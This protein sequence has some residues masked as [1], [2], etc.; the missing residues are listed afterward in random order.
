MTSSFK[1][2]SI[3]TSPARTICSLIALSVGL[4]ACGGGSS[5]IQPTFVTPTT[6]TPTTTPI[7]NQP[8]LASLRTQ[9]FNRQWALGAVKAEYAYQK[10]MTGKGVIIG[11]VDFNFD[12]SSTEINFHAASRDKGQKWVDMYEAQIGDL[13]PDT[14]HGEATITIA[15]AKKNGIATHGVAYGAQ[16]MAIDYFSGVNMDVQIQNG[17]HWQVS[18]PYTYLIE[19]G[20]RIVNISLGYDEE[21]II[22]NPPAVD[23]DPVSG[24]VEKYYVDTPAYVIEG[25]GLLVVSAGNAGVGATVGDPDPQLSIVDNLPNRKGIIAIATDVGILNGTGAGGGLIIAGAV[26]QQNI[27]ASFSDRAGDIV[28]NGKRVMDFYLVAPGVDIQFPYGEGETVLYKG[29][30]T[31]FAAPLISGAAAI[32]MQSWPTLTAWEVANVLFDSAT[33]LGAPG[34]DV[35]YGRGLLNLQAA[36]EPIGQTTSAAPGGITPVPI[37]GNALVLPPAFGDG[38]PKQISAI[39]GLDK[40]GRDFYFDLTGAVTQNGLAPLSLDYMVNHRM[41]LG[42]S[43]WQVGNNTLSASVVEL[44]MNDTVLAA[45]SQLVKS[46]A[47]MT[48]PVNLFATGKINKNLNWQA[49]VGFA[50]TNV[51]EGNALQD[52]TGINLVTRSL[53]QSY[54]GTGGQFM[55]FNYKVGAATKFGFG[56]TLG[57]NKGY[58]H[59]TDVAFNQDSPTLGWVGVLS[60]QDNNRDYAFTLGGLVER[61]G[62]LGSRSSGNFGLASEAITNFVGA[63]VRQYIGNDYSL[64]ASV[65]AGITDPK[66]A[67][68]SLFASLDQIITSEWGVRFNSPDH[69]TK[70]GN[71]A[72]S[73]SQPL[74]VEQANGSMIV[75]TG[76]DA[77]T[78]VPEFRNERISFAPSG[79]EIAIEA[80]WRTTGKSFFGGFGGHWAVEASIL[81]REDAGHFKGLRDTAGL[82]RMK[83]TF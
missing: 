79:R 83:L 48:K 10:G 52:T 4:S 47:Q 49:G 75:G 54:M 14:P 33:D 39:M 73:I 64:E 80:A 37:S 11:F 76:L 78:G 45:Q 5:Y 26:D 17:V 15:A 18:N 56:M 69:L 35:I 31:S 13:A 43:Q 68:N 41:N 27:I 28:I 20:A 32:V 65:K 77:V 50:L 9:E 12:L 46:T 44:G 60:H 25:G 74:R 59:P 6:R 72:L 29:G 19:N 30:G 53:R 36:M 1:T 42:N 16:I 61:Q 55:A 51:L 62:I 3:K 2:S 21:D 58:Q 66:G 23:P 7:S 71:F 24:N 70:N 82:V 8:T 67:A 57:K 40:Y 38:M 63:S 81:H 22:L 34:T